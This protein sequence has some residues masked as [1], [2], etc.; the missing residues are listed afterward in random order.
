[1][2]DVEMNVW[3][4][5]LGAPFKASQAR[6]ISSGRARA[7]LQIVGPSTSCAMRRTAS[8][9]PGEL[10]ANPASM[11]STPSR[12][13][14]LATINFSSGFMA[15]P[16]DCSPSRSVVSKMRIRRLISFLELARHPFRFQATTGRPA[17]QVD[18]QHHHARQGVAGEQHEQRDLGRRRDQHDP[19]HA[20]HQIHEAFPGPEL[21]ALE[22]R[23]LDRADHQEGQDDQVRSEEHTSELQSLAYLV[24][25]LLLEKKKKRNNNTS[26]ILQYE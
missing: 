19:Q 25:R 14:C 22:L 23:V 8:K 4:R 21:H 15:A 11:M 10:Y 3:M 5:T 9:S 26:R 20:P 2:S 12:A 13:N 24:C 18:C 16:G 1:M 7:R 6:S 17:H